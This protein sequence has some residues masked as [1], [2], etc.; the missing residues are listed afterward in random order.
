M[1]IAGIVFGIIFYGFIS[2][3]CDMVNAAKHAGFKW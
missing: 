1:T 3:I 2:R